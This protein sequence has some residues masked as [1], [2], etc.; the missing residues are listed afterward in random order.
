MNIFCMKKCKLK[1]NNLKV[2][3]SLKICYNC[4]RERNSSIISDK[5]KADKFTLEGLSLIEDEHKKIK[6]YLT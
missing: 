1:I 3:N 4:Y 2:V 5:S 6:E